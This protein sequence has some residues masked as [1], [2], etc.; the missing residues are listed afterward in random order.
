VADV[1]KPL[2]ILPKEKIPGFVLNRC[3]SWPEKPDND[4]SDK[5]ALN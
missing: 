5:A 1:N 4:I 2:Q 3:E